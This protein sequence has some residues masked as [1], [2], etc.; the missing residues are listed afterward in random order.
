M[1]QNPNIVKDITKRRLIWAGHAW[2][3]EGSMLRTVIERVPQG[4]R[5]LGRPRLRWEDRVKEDVEKV[6]PGEDWKELSL[7]RESWRQIC[8]TV[9][10]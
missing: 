6:K 7:E 3:K 5:P 8:W 10:S 2:R 1:Y 9:W 4:K